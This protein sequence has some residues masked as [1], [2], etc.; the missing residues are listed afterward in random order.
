MPLSVSARRRTSSSAAGTGIRSDDSAAVTASAPARSCSTGRSACP[1]V[2]QTPLPRPPQRRP[3]VEQRAPDEPQRSSTPSRASPQAAA[4]L[5]PGAARAPATGRST[6][7][8]RLDHHRLLTPPDAP[9]A[10]PTPDVRLE[11]YAAHSGVLRRPMT[12]GH[13]VPSFRLAPHAASAG[14]SGHCTGRSHA[15]PVRRRTV[16]ALRPCAGR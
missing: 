14:S 7:R 3:A 6:A 8:G 13:R 16:Q 12:S 4:G 1:T 10:E 2:R 9:S 11:R 15:R 5:C